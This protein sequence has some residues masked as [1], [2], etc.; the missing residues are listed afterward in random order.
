MPKIPFDKKVLI[1]KQLSEKQQRN[2][3]LVEEDSKRPLTT[4]IED[5]FLPRRKRKPADINFYDLGQIK[6]GEIYQTLPFTHIPTISLSVDG[7][8]DGIVYFGLSEFQDLKDEIFS[9]GVANLKDN[10]KKIE[11]DEG[12]RYGIDIYTG[13][14][15]DPVDNAMRYPVSKDGERFFM[16][17]YATIVS[18]SKW[19]E[20]GLKI[21]SGDLNFFSVIC[22]SISI[23]FGTP[24]TPVK[25]T[26]TDNYSAAA[27]DGF[28]YTTGMNVFLMPL[29]VWLIAS[30]INGSDGQSN[31]AGLLFGIQSREFW[32][33]NPTVADLIEAGT[34]LRLNLFS[35]AAEDIPLLDLESDLVEYFQNLAGSRYYLNATTEYGDINDFPIYPFGTIDDVHRFAF[36]TY[37]SFGTPATTLQ[38]RVKI[39]PGVLLAVIEK[40]GSYF[41]VWATADFNIQKGFSFRNQDF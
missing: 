29:P 14:P 24:D 13:D 21:P 7:Y 6:V 28:S 25:I 18:D 31:L 37:S 20:T 35:I 12:W 22:E 11:Y 41:Y 30:D 9:V 10:Y 26:A 17:E 23:G 27:I 16:N 34:G 33:D 5:E 3:V 1:E 2:S 32:L 39:E 19:T 38:G 8:P 15:D 36:L 40:S 4:L